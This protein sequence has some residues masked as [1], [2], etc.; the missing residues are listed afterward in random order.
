MASPIKKIPSS[1]INKDELLDTMESMRQADG[2]WKEGRTWS[3]VYYAG[4]EHYDFLKKAHNKFFSEN[5]LNPMVFQSLKKMEAD[6]VGMTANMLNGGPEAVGTMTSGGTESILM[7]VKAARERARKLRI[8]PEKPE[9]VAPKTIH[10]AMDKAAHYFGLKMRYAPI[11]ENYQVDVE[12]MK[13][14]VNRNTVLLAASAPQYA[15]GMI[16]PIEEIGLLALDHQIPFHVDACFG[17]FFLPWMEKLGYE[18]PLWDFRVPGVTSISADVHKYGYGAK[19][20]STIIYRDMSYLKHQFFVSTNWPGGIYASPSFPGTRPGGPIAASWAALQALGED[21]YLR[22]ARD[23][24]DAVEALKAGIA[25]IDALEILGC[26][27]GPM[28]C[29]AP[30]HPDVDIYAVADQLQKKGWNLD[31]QQKPASIHCSVTGHHKAFV[32]EFLED[33]A[34]V[35][36]LVKS[37]PELKNEGQAP[38]YGMMAKIPFR[39]AVKYSVLKVM[40]GM[41]GPNGQVPDLGKLGEGDDASPLFK[42]MNKYGDQAMELLARLENP[43]EAV[44]DGVGKMLKY[45]GQ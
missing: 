13:K 42:A 32:P 18:L 40:E 20:A 8:W 39:G 38:M 31:R 34:E 12:A 23:T 5:G 30:A 37:H 27:H 3:L 2:D 26:E 43:K 35:T 7:A 17:G 44:K 29:I 1:G 45:F 24:M 10:V 14:L 9:I 21:G 36:A 6:V 28:V 19:G 4:E 11:D 15:H 25:G 16:D 22:L 33:L 41:Y